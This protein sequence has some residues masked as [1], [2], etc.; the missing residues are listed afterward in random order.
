M[1]ENLVP[2]TYI[3]VWNLIQPKVTTERKKTKWRPAQSTTHQCLQQK[4][5]FKEEEEE[6]EEEEKAYYTEGPLNF[7]SG[8]GMAWRV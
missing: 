7:E 1:G 6:E 3:S 2:F 4:E 5:S 8:P